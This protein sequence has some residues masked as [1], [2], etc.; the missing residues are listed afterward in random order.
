MLGDQLR[1]LI[2]TRRKD[3]DGTVYQHLPAGQVTRVGQADVLYLDEPELSLRD[4]MQYAQISGARTVYLNSFFSPLSFSF[5]LLRRLG[6]IKMQLILAPRGEFS[7]GAYSIKKWKKDIYRVV[8]NK[9]KILDNIY[10]HASTSHE[11]EDIRHVIGNVKDIFVA[12]DPF[13]LGEFVVGDHLYDLAYISRITPKKNLHYSLECL[14]M[15]KQEVSLDIYGPIE[16]EAYWRLCRQK[17]SA[18]PPHITVKYCGLLEY[19][20]VR[21]TFAKYSAFLFPTQ[22]ENYGHVIP[23]ALSAGTPVILSDQT[24]WQDLEEAGIGYVIPLNQPKRFAQAIEALLHCSA[25]ERQ[26]R[27]ERCVA[28]AR[29][30]EGQEE[31]REQ[32][33]Q[34]FSQPFRRG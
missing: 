34:L 17:I 28:Y 10:W 30:V 2:L 4:L 8:L 18:L 26:V 19:D 29:A 25:D 3:I 11:L 15:C 14:A 33:L 7:L 23:E 5:L 24:P 16:D 1:F 13:M 9:M 20:Q 31:V 32:N 27:A 21:P 6:V 12:P 22:G